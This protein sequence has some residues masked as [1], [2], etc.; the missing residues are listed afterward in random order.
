MS[1]TSGRAPSRAFYLYAILSF[2]LLLLL[3]SAYHSPSSILFRPPSSALLT[4][5][6]ATTRFST[7]AHDPFNLLS[8]RDH[9]ELTTSPRSQIT[10]SP[11]LGFGHIYVLSLPNREDRR[12]QM[13]VLARALGIRIT[14]V[15]A[16]D[17]GEPWIKWIAERVV[18][19]R[20]KKIKLMVRPLPWL[21]R[22]RS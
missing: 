4:S 17:K 9:L 8:F 14:F 5:P 18:E 3:L 2:G 20:R 22:G 21:E 19:V 7:F 15:D 16:A 12:K 13:E 6:D 10:H 1:H 11:T